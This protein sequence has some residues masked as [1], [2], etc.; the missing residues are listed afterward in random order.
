MGGRGV[1][2][3]PTAAKRLLVPEAVL[4]RGDLHELGY[5]RRAVDAI[6]LACPTQHWPGYSW[7][8]ILVADFLA[9][10]ERF[11]RDEHLRSAAGTD[12]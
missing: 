6:F 3:R 4:T 8:V 11:T 2:E 9:A 5:G 1:S 7:P 10:R 12:S